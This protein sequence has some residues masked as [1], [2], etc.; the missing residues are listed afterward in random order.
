MT[1]KP[2]GAG[3]ALRLN[4][5]GAPLTWHYLPGVPGIFHPSIPTPLERLGMELDQAKAYSDDESLHVELVDISEDDAKTADKSLSEALGL[6]MA[7]VKE[8]LGQRETAE[9][10][11]RILANAD[12]AKAVKAETT[13]QE[14]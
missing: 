8:A 10:R 9:E 2:K 13:K 1:T 4:L 6:T 12:A 14:G 7:G 11:D 5:P 3:K